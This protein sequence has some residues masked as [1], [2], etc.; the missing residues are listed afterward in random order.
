MIMKKIK[1]KNIWNNF[2]K[3]DM[4]SF[5]QVYLKEVLSDLNVKFHNI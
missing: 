2:L 1:F 3:C 4:K 5:T